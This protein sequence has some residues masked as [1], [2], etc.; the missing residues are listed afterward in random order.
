MDS[1]FLPPCGQVEAQKSTSDRAHTY[2]AQLESLEKRLEV[3]AA[4]F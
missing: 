2:Q 4:V 1:E 3:T